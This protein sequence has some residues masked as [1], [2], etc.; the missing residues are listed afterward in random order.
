MANTKIS[1]FT[2]ATVM[3][4]AQFSIIQGGTNKRASIG[5]LFLTG[6]ATIDF[7]SVDDNASSAA[8]NVTVTGAV[9]GDFV[10][11]VTAS[12]NIA[13]TDGIFLLG[14]ITAAGVC[15]VTLHNDSAGAFDAASQTIYVIV[16]PKASFGL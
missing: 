10:L 5:L 3:T 6:S 4:G 2:A 1:A 11:D 14:K 15:E 9:V 12:G 8:S 7:G 16:I 13:T